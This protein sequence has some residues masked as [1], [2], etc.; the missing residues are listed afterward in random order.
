MSVWG[1]T[2]FHQITIS[3]LKEGVAPNVPNSVWRQTVVQATKLGPRGVFFF[4]LFFLLLQLPSLASQDDL[5]ISSDRFWPVVLIHCVSSSVPDDTRKEDRLKKEDALK[6]S[7]LEF[8]LTNGGRKGRDVPPG[9][10]SDKN[11]KLTLA[12]ALGKL[13]P[14]RP[15]KRFN[16]VHRTWRNYNDSK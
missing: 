9:F 6:L 14:C 16:L 5:D 4:F 12:Q 3:S 7:R 11:E 10:S 1:N 2:E 8:D 15:S 13:Q